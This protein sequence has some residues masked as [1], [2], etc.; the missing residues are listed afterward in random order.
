MK[1]LIADHHAVFRHG[2]QD[3]LARHFPDATFAEA[4]SAEA[5]LKLVWKERWDLLLLDGTMCGG[6]DLEILR[7]IKHG[8][9][10]LPVLILS[11]RAENQ[12][13]LRVFQAG[14]AGYLTKIDPTA[15][16]LHAVEK[17]LGGGTYIPMAISR[18]LV[19]QLRLGDQCPD[20]RKLS[21]RESEILRLLVS[22]KPAKAIAR[23]LCLSA[24]TISTYRARILKKFGLHSTAELIRYAIQNRLV[25]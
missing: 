9:P 25:D 2:L 3:I 4:D 14:A 13:G 5:A 11:A 24:Q 23:D 12:S 1:I 10:R 18:A 19:H 6:S 8:Q 16:L 7:Q 15:E 22:G 21:K 17:V 20:Q